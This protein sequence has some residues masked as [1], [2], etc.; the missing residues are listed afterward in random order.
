MLD[1]VWG[2]EFFT[3]FP[4]GDFK[5]ELPQDF[6]T[7]KEAEKYGNEQFGEGNYVIETPF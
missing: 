7:R 3:V 5:D 1:R 2:D 4:V 6:P